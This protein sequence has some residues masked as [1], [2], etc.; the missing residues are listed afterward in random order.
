MMPCGPSTPPRWPLWAL[1]SLLVICSLIHIHVVRRDTVPSIAD[2]SGYYRTSLMLYRHLQADQTEQLIQHL[3]HPGIRPPLPLLVTFALFWTTGDCSETMARH[4]ILVF[5]VILV[6]CTYAIGARLQD[7]P[8][9]LVAAVLVA[10]FP[11]VIGF[12]RIYW[13][14]LP[15]AAMTS[16]SIWALLLTERFRRRWASLLFGLT[17]G[18]GLLTKYAFVVFIAGP[19]FI[20]LLGGRHGRRG[21]RDRRSDPLSRVLSNVAL[22]LVAAITLCGY[23][24]LKTIGYALQNF[25]FNRGTGVL[26]A[27]AWWSVD[28]LVIYPAYLQLQLGI[29]CTIALVLTLPSFLRHTSR[30][31]RLLLLSWLALPYLFFTF[32]VLGIE[33]SRFTLPYLPAIALIISL[34]LMQFRFSSFFSVSAAAFSLFSLLSV[35]RHSYAEPQQLPRGLFP[36]KRTRFNGMLTAESFD[37]HIP[38]QKLTPPNLTAELTHAAVLPDLGTLASLLETWA[39]QQRHPVRFSVPYEPESVDFIGFSFPGRIGNPDYLKRFDYVLK[40]IPPPHMRFSV[41]R[42]VDYQLAEQSWQLIR[43]SFTRR[44][45]LR[46]PNGA[47]LESYR[48]HSP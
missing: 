16:L 5:F 2:A 12:S 37:F 40:V 47:M 33:W 32:V 26:Q 27:R 31:T 11:Q 9:G 48:K 29:V 19:F 3:F 22:M 30:D 7:R 23:W 15:L 45:R 25:L 13:M 6:C 14:D 18:L 34:S 43:H 10:S 46:L 44:A 1:A 28:N 35:F 8:T 39:L 4:S 21:R 17:V 41:R 38:I 36:W 24:Y 20:V 42:P